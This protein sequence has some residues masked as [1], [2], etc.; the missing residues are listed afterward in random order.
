MLIMKI[1][2]H[3]TLLLTI[4]NELKETVKTNHY[5]THTCYSPAMAV[6]YAMGVSQGAAFLA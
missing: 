2:F 6:T 1:Y 5:N 3:F 4:P